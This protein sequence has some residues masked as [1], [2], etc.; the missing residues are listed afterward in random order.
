MGSSPSLDGKL[1]KIHQI[2]ATA[3]LL[4]VAMSAK[5]QDAQPGERKVVAGRILWITFFERGC[6]FE[7]REPVEA[8][9]LGQPQVLTDPPGM[10]IEGQNKL[11]GLE[12][13][14]LWECLL[15]RTPLAPK[16]GI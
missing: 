9:S 13:P 11:G 10:S 15:K 12:I 1:A 5:I 6:D 14:G 4:N 3:D 8:L 2:T 7:R 16:P